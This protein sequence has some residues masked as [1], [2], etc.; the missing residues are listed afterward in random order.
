MNYFLSIWIDSGGMSLT[1]GKSMLLDLQSK[2]GMHYGF[3]I[4]S[5]SLYA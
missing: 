3:P 1:K 2:R 5:D 4:R